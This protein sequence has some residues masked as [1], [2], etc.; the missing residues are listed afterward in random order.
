LEAI[1]NCR[2]AENLIVAGVYGRLTP[3]E[4]AELENHAGACPACAGLMAKSA[5]LL[6][7]RARA[8]EDDV[9][10]PDWEKSWSRIAAEALDK[11][12]RRPGVFGRTSPGWP[13]WAIRATAAAAV[14][15]VFV[16]GYFTGRGV[17]FDRPGETAAAGSSL[18]VSPAAESGR[19]ML[20]EYADNLGPVLVNFLNRGGVRP[21]EGLRELERH[22]VRDMIAQTRLLRS[23]AAADGG[24]E[25][26]L[27]ELLQD[28]EFILTSLA[29]MAPDDK[30]SADQL[31]RMIR[32]TDVSLRLRDLAAFSTI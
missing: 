12:P 3:E 10:L 23:L 24:T 21:P 29:N 1:M 7:L 27:G 28:L 5:P 14:L 8:G 22:V 15:A 2:E 11:R 13:V 4:R 31:D 26:R 18:P 30:E 6:G 9:P 16:L 19:I 32:E 17:L 20:A 25:G